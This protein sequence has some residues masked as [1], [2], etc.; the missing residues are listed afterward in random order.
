[1]RKI[2]STTAMN[3]EYLMCCRLRLYDELMKRLFTFT[4]KCFNCDNKL[5]RH[6]VWYGRMKS[7]LS[8]SVFLL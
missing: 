4:H 7:P 1:M 8:F 6:A 3:Q 5:V 2:K